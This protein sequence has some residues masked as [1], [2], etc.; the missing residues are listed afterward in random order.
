M[1]ILYLIKVWNESILIF[2]PHSKFIPVFKSDIIPKSFL[3]TEVF[4]LLLPFNLVQNVCIVFLI[5]CL[6]LYSNKSKWFL[7]SFLGLLTLNIVYIMLVGVI[8]GSFKIYFIKEFTVVF[9]KVR[10]VFKVP[11]NIKKIVEF[12][13]E[14]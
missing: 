14:Q 10:L 8:Y 5:R 2:L 1:Y 4:T 12:T 9:N 6:Y 7:W 11:F 3:H 13:N